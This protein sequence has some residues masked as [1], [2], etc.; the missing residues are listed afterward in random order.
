MQAYL[1]KPD[2]CTQRVSRNADNTKPCSRQDAEAHK[3]C[4]CGLLCMLAAALGNKREWHYKGR[5]CSGTPM[6]FYEHTLAP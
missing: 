3:A 1:M 2:R 6:R 4:S 5:P